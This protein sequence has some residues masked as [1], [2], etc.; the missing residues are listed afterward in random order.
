MRQTQGPLVP[1]QSRAQGL[2]RHHPQKL[3]RGADHIR[4][5]AVLVLQHLQRRARAPVGMLG[6]HGEG[7]SGDVGSLEHGSRVHTADETAHIVVGGVAQDVV[8]RA[9]LH[10]LPVFHDGDAVANAHGLVQIVRDEDDGAP[11]H[12]LQAQQL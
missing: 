12:L 5:L 1:C 4:V 10:H 7:L 9:H 6:H 11:P 8:G 2:C 3:L